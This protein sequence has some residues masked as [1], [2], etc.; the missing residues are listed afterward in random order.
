M[1]ALLIL[2]IWVVCCL[3]GVGT[4]FG[5]EPEGLNAETRLFGHE[6]EALGHKVGKDDTA[7][8]EKYGLVRIG[9]AYYVPATV[10]FGHEPSRRECR[11]NGVKVQSRVGEKM[12][13]ALLSTRRY[14]RLLG[15]GLCE[16]IEISTRGGHR[17]QR[18]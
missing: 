16:R 3:M 9:C 12:A 14:K 5:Q 8:V 15:S 17:G 18:R 2:A 4:A 10:S 6:L 7:F 11:R 13:T 1:R